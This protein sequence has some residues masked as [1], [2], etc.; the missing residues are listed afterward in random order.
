MVKTGLP[1]LLL[2]CKTRRHAARARRPP[3]SRRACATTAVPE[4]RQARAGLRD[5][6]SVMEPKHQL[7]RHAPW[8]RGQNAIRPRNALSR[9]GSA[10]S[11]ASGRKLPADP[12]INPEQLAVGDS[13]GPQR[14]EAPN[15]GVRRGRPVAR[16]LVVRAPARDLLL[17]ANHLLVAAIVGPLD[18]CRPG[19]A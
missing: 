15:E 11:S 4:P 6:P 13:A 3:V 9:R 10:R 19:D 12:S 5:A 14:D 7:A 1:P 16:L 2:A 17:Q 8:L 18:R